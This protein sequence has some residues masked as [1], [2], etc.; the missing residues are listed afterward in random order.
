MWEKLWPE[1]RNTHTAAGG[2]SV[3]AADKVG[4]VQRG[5]YANEFSVHLF[6]FQVDGEGSD[7]TDSEKKTKM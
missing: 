7:A 5:C 4:G 6:T 1:C 2:V 3:E